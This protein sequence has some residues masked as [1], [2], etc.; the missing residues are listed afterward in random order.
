[1]FLSN[2]AALGILKGNYNPGEY[3]P[4]VI[5]DHPDTVRMSIIRN[6]DPEELTKLLVK[7]ETF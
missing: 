2:P 4:R 6:V 7:L 1:M 3:R 5:I